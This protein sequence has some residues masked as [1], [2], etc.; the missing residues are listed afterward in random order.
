MVRG[1]V[2]EPIHHPQSLSISLHK[3][4]LSAS[5]PKSLSISRLS[6]NR[7]PLSIALKPHVSLTIAHNTTQEIHE[8]MVSKESRV[9]ISPSAVTTAPMMLKSSS[10][11]S[12]NPGFLILGFRILFSDF[13][14]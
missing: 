5:L 9:K 2:T 3:I 8:S 7:S 13:S 14:S 11:A 12:S 10:F 6:H 4:A 1:T